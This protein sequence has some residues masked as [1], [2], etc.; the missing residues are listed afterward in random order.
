MYPCS[1]KIDGR[2]R[3]CCASKMVQNSLLESK[4]NNT[5][6]KLPILKL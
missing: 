6:S 4:N 1:N 3:E 5:L 2:E